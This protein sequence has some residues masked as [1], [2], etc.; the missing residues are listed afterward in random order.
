VTGVITEKE[1]PKGYACE[2]CGTE[3][4]FPAYVYAHWEVRITHS[5]DCGAKH[6]VLCGVATLV[7]QNEE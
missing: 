5:C 3:H 6:S 4:R 2:A 1:L 7:E